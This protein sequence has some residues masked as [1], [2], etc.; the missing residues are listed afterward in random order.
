MKVHI[1]LLLREIIATVGRVK[2]FLKD[3]GIIAL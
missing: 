2:D 3:A 1:P